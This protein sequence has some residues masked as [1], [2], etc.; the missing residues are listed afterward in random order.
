MSGRLGMTG[1]G[2]DYGAAVFGKA[3]GNKAWMV[4]QGA[5]GTRAVMMWLQSVVSEP[6][7]Y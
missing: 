5:G 3:Q 4:Y 2:V 1:G 6:Y 7:R